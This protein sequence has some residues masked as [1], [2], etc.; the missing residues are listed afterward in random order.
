M[1]RSENTEAY[2]P[3][4]A[5]NAGF[6][7]TVNK[8]ENVNTETETLINVLRERM[9]KMSNEARLDLMATLMEGYCRYCCSDYLPCYCINDD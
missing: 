4:V 8:E 1:K 3:A 5:S 6:G 9:E 2:S 7:V